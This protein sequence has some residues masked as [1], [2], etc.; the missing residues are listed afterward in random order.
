MKWACLCR[1]LK[2]FTLRSALHE[3]LGDA[4]RPRNGF[5]F[6]RVKKMTFE[7]IASPP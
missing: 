3:G 5:A 2:T 4:T 1:N 7:G 6:P